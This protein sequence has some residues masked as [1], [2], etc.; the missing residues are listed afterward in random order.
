MG[1]ERIFEAEDSPIVVERIEGEQP[2]RRVVVGSELSGAIALVADAEGKILLVQQYRRALDTTLWE[3]R[4]L[5]RTGDLADA[6]S[7]AA[8]AMVTMM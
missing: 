5:V 8:L 1:W 3:L 7:L 4:E 2:Q 6:M